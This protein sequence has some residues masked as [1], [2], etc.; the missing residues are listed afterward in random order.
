LR[1]GSEE[2]GGGGSAWHNTKQNNPNRNEIN[3]GQPGRDGTEMS[4]IVRW[5][6]CGMG[7]AAG[8]GDA[9]RA[10]R[11][12]GATNHQH[13]RRA[14]TRQARQSGQGGRVS[15][16]PFSTLDTTLAV[17]VAGENEVS[18]GH[19]RPLSGE[20]RRGDGVM[21]DLEPVGA[22]LVELETCLGTQESRT[23][24]RRGEREELEGEGE[25][26]VRG[27][28]RQVPEGFRA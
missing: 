2:G 1:R 9:H 13:S 14:H 7:H 26:G 18:K 21:R 20:A 4:C 28:A 11:G 19:H 6:G 24:S 16:A 10:V 12:G 22:G 3:R 27:R 5:Q 15:R 8:R 17:R 23:Q 25:G